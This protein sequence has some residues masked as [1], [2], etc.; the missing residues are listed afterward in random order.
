[1]STEPVPAAVPLTVS[2]VGPTGGLSN[3]IRYGLFDVAGWFDVQDVICEPVTA[4]WAAAGATASAMSAER[5]A[6]IRSLGIEKVPFLPILTAPLHLR[7][8]ARAVRTSAG[9]RRTRPSSPRTPHPT[10]IG[11]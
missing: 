8:A 5:V 6:A 9:T 10:C 7:A 11:P 4:A 1:M 3:E 2:V